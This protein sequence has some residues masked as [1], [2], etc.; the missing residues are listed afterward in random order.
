MEDV[1]QVAVLVIIGVL[2][3]VML[4]GIRVAKEHE[5]FAVF[6]LGRFFALRGPGLV[7]SLPLLQTSVRL[8]IG[9]KGKFK[10]DDVA[11]FHGYGLPVTVDTAVGVNTPV[12]I[13]S[14]SDAQVHVERSV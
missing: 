3:L 5:R 7:I 1:R 11:E 4:A 14:F 12:R 2:F 13:R 9:D 10:G 6:I 8:A